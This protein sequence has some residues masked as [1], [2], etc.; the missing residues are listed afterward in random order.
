[1]S[2]LPTL[3]SGLYYIHFDYGFSSIVQSSYTDWERVGHKYTLD[4]WKTAN[5]MT[6]SNSTITA[7]S[8][9]A[10]LGFGRRMMAKRNGD[11]AAFA[12]G[13]YTTANNANIGGT[14]LAT[15]TMEYSRVNGQGNRQTQFYVFDSTRRRIINIDL[16]GNGLKKIPHLCYNCHETSF[17]PFDLD[18]LGYPDGNSRND[19]ESEFKILNEIVR[20]TNPRA[21]ASELIGLWYAKGSTQQSDVIPSEWSNKADN[22][23]ISYSY[24]LDT[25][26]AVTK[27]ERAIK[28]WCV[29]NVKS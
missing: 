9:D 1:M 3:E 14:P 6:E 8:N 7:Y 5:S 16:D 15:V 17:I 13:N 20:D 24:N 18:S 21:R 11:E 22:S 12:V 4:L 23:N 25:N 29:L 28:R 10:D 19:Q 2:K 26:Q 27:F